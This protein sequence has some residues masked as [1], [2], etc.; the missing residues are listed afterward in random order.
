MYSPISVISA[1][2]AFIKLCNGRAEVIHVEYY[3]GDSVYYKGYDFNTW[4]E[5]SELKKELGIKSDDDFISTSSLSLALPRVIRTLEYDEFKD[6][7]SVG[8]PTRKA[9]TR[10]DKNTCQYCGKKFHDSGLNRDHIIPQSRDGES[11]WEN[12]VA[13]CFKCNTKKDNRTPKE[14]G[15]KL[16]SKPVKPKFIPNN[17]FVIKDKR[18][19][20]WKHFVSEIYWNVE[21]ED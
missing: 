1:K 8:K 18:Y 17:D 21:L 11:T 4:A 20:T 13:S 3:K 15:M 19:I 7:S 9:I 12:L 6:I 14:A 10:R 16:L 2:E 5:L